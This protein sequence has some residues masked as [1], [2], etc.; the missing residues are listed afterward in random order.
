M[1]KL[2]LILLCYPLIGFSQANYNITINT[3]NAWSGNL[4][5]QKGGQPI[6]PV[7]IIDS[8]GTEI[9]SENWTMKGWDFKVNYNNKLSYF[10][11]A[12]HGWFIMD[13]LQNEVDSVYFQNGYTADNHDFLALANGNYVLIAY[14]EQPYA[15]DTVVTGGDPNATVEGLIIQELDPNHNVIFEWKSWDHFH[16][17]DNTYMSPWTGASL[18]FIHAN[19]IDIDF[20]GHFII[21]SRGLD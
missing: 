11:R 14:D 5:F 18:N 17:T 15:M 2:L 12:T 4:F 6:K 20:D 16:V 9:F 21:S 3:N 10:D 1:K 8:T 7:K 13:S 19:A